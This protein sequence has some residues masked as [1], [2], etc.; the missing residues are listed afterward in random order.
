MTPKMQKGCVITNKDYTAT[1][2]MIKYYGISL[3]LFVN[4]NIRSFFCHDR[5]FAHN[6][7]LLLLIINVYIPF[8]EGT[9]SP[10][11][12][13]NSISRFIFVSTTEGA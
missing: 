2:L 7:T 6:A 4:D 9:D 5:G 3:I 12:S 1:L 8:R 10:S 11:T 13:S